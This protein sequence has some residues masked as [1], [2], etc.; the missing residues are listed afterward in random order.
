MP[1]DTAQFLSSPE[2]VLASTLASTN[3]EAATRRP[4]S[5]ELGC[6]YHQVDNVTL[7]ADWQAP[8]LNLQNKHTA[9][10]GGFRKTAD[11]Q[12]LPPVCQEW[13]ESLLLGLR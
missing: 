7:Q 2:A 12:Y 3:E 11:W 6:P 8:P 5:W 1:V 13:L 10:W 9:G 4:F